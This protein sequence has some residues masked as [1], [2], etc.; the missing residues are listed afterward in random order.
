MPVCLISYLSILQIIGHRHSGSRQ[1]A[2]LSDQD[3]ADAQPLGEQ[4]PKQEAPSIQPCAHTHRERKGGT[5]KICI[6]YAHQQ[7]F[8]SY[9]RLLLFS[10]L[11]SNPPACDSSSRVL[12]IG[13]SLLSEQLG[14]SEGDRYLCRTHRHTCQHPVQLD[15]SER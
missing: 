1:F 12:Q 10:Y 7:C 13:R 4:R 11:R 2:L 8:C 9:F 15:I 6:Q 14:P 5:R 3:K